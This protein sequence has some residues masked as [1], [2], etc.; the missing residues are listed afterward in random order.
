MLQDIEN[1]T[2]IA[3]AVDQIHTDER[4]A[5]S[6]ID[7]ETGHRVRITF[8]RETPGQ[9]PLENDIAAAGLVLLLSVK[10][11]STDA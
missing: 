5:F 10:R 6:G 9:S 11:L 4:P 2:P 8:E 3:V 1:F 7:L